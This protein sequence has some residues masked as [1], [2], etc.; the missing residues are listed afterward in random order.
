[1]KGLLNGLKV[2]GV[3]MLIG[4]AGALDCMMIDFHR[5]VYQ[6]LVGIGTVLLACILPHM[7][8]MLRRMAVMLFLFR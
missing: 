6:V 2:I 8:K 4:T 3:F 1:M 7:G 5:A